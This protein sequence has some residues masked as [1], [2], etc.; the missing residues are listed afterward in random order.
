MLSKKHLIRIALSAGFCLAAVA[1]AGLPW[2]LAAG[3]LMETPCWRPPATK[4]CSGKNR[5]EVR[6]EHGRDARGA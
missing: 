3:T 4:A 5:V 6:Y 2:A 1:F